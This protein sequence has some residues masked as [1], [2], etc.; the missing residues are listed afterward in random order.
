MSDGITDRALAVLEV[1]K[2]G[3]SV[4]DLPPATFDTSSGVPG[5]SSQLDALTAPPPRGAVSRIN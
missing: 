2:F 4:I 1:Q 5:P 3:A